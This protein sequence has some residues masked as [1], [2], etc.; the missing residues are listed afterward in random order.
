MACRGARGTRASARKAGP[1]ACLH[2]PRPPARGAAAC[3]PAAGGHLPRRFALTLSTA[4]GH[5][6]RV[7][8]S[9]W[10]KKKN[11]TGSCCT[12]GSQVGQWVPPS[13][14]CDPRGGFACR[15]FCVPERGCWWPRGPA[16]P[17][18]AP[19]CPR[20]SRIRQKTGWGWGE[21]HK[22]PQAVKETLGTEW[23]SFFLL[24]IKA[25]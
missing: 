4:S 3:P 10:Q 20:L 8:M 23:I 2:P 19:H 1:Q 17:V 22:L 6:R 15:S 11:G 24:A 7:R 21:F 13:P 25:S 18:P 9:C 14:S 16:T 12:S 5:Q